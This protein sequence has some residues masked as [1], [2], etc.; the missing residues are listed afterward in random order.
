M[1]PWTGKTIAEAGTEL[2]QEGIDLYARY[3]DDASNLMFAS[4]N[5]PNSSNYA[6]TR[7]GSDSWHYFNSLDALDEFVKTTNQGGLNLF[8]WGQTTTTTSGGWRFG[9]RMLYLPNKGT[10]QLNWKQNAGYLRQ[11]MSRGK[12]IFD[13]FV[14]PTGQQIPTGGFLRAERFL[15]ESRGWQFNSKF[16]AYIPP[17][18]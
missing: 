18:N 9:D 7:L 17:K 11:E 5:L 1:N 12:P 6:V 16:R 4:G 10:P 2:S 15:L 14:S 8:K 13:S 3:G